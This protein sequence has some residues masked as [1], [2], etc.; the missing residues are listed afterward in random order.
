MVLNTMEPRARTDGM[1]NTCESLKSIVNSNGP[2]VLIGLS[3]N[4]KQPGSLLY[5]CR[6]ADKCAVGVVME[7]N[8]SLSY[9]RNVVTPYL[10]L[11]E[12]NSQEKLIEMRRR[13]GE[14]SKCCVCNDTDRNQYVPRESG[15]T[16]T[17]C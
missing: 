16:F 7:S 14:G 6:I 1:T 5:R 3:Q 11:W 17:R 13:D 4:G 8:P 15:P 10:S 12:S 2:K 9:M